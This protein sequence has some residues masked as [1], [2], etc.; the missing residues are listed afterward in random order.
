MPGTNGSSSPSP[1]VLPAPDSPSLSARAPSSRSLSVQ[2]P[3][4]NSSFDGK[5]APSRPPP[6]SRGSYGHL[7]YYQLH[8]VCKRKG[9]SRKD[10]NAALKI[11]LAP[12][13]EVDRNR[14]AAGGRAMETSGTLAGKRGRA[15]VDAAEISEGAS[16]ES[17][18]ACSHGAISTWPFSRMPE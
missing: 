6:V 15:P 12:M 7:S 17:G 4:I 16:Y 5:C 18:E 10:S 13:G 9:Y 3:L 2:L 11:R 14:K 1:R 8:E